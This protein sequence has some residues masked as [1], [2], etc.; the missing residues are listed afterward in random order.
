MTVSMHAAAKRMCEHSGWSLS[1]LKLQ[2]LL[3]IA[4]M[5][6]IGET[7]EP[8][9]SDHFEAWN[10]GPVNPS[11]YHLMKIFGSS[12]VGN[13]FHSIGELE[14]CSERETLDSA[15]DQLGNAPSGKLVA[16]THWKKGAWAKHYI[17]SMRN[18]VIPNEDIRQEYL[19]RKDVAK[20]QQTEN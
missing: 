15:I 20:E 3:Y 10:Y 13:V 16:I 14:E 19:D 9:V 7:D 17:P 18:I 2:K 11:L 4:H 1:N 12:P 5:F 8:L 6:H